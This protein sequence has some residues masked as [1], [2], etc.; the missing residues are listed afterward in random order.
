MPLALLQPSEFRGPPRKSPG[1]HEPGIRVPACGIQ[2]SSVNTTYPRT[3][4]PKDTRFGYVERFQRATATPGPG[5]YS[6]N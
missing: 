4:A 5:A 2:Y 3:G 1:P 6:P